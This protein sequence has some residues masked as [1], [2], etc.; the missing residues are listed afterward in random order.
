M[1]DESFFLTMAGLAMSFAGFAGLMNALRRRG[2]A[3]APMEL[4]QLRI[5]VAYAIAT[6]FGSLSTIPFV[7]LIGPREG[8][9]WL[10]LVMLI[11]SSALGLG[12][13]ISDIRQGHGIVLPTR[14][15]ATFT[16]ITILGLVA[17]L[18]TAITGAPV[19]YRIALILML[20]MPAGTFAYVVARLER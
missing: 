1:I 18:G 6:L 2:D 19:L 9:Q 4:Y 20:A 12:N 7:E 3:W 15:R 8:L 14:V 10:A 5:I 11:V 17:L 13:M 16:A